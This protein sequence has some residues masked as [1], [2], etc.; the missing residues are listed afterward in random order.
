MV[1]KFTNRRKWKAVIENILHHGPLVYGFKPMLMM[2]VSKWPFSLRIYKIPSL[3]NKFNARS[4]C[5]CY[6]HKRRYLISEKQAGIHAFRYPI[7]YLKAHVRGHHFLQI[8]GIAKEF[9]N[10]VQLGPNYLFLFKS[11]HSPIIDTQR[12]QYLP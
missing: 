3:F 1:K 11:I 12:N 9:P 2:P 5:Q 8:L 4:P 7:Q 10:F 6:T